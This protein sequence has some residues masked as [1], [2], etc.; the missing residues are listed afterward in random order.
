MTAAPES[1]RPDMRTQLTRQ[2]R[3]IAWGQPFAEIGDRFGIRISGQHYSG[4]TVNARCGVGVAPH[5]RQFGQAIE[6]AGRQIKLGAHFRHLLMRAQGGLFALAART[7]HH[8]ACQQ[9]KAKRADGDGNRRGVGN[10]S[11]CERRRQC[12]R[13]RKKG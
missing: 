3:T 9:A 11:C 2:V 10:V 5:D 1:T 8:E 12:R 13:G 7:A 4:L 6:H